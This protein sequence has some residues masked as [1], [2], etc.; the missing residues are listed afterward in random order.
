VDKEDKWWKELE[1]MEEYIEEKVKRIVESKEKRWKK[2]GKV[3]FGRNEYIFQT[4]PLFES[5]E[6]L[7]V[8]YVLRYQKIHTWL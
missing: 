7:V 3:I 6:L 1:D 2:E 8:S 4:Q 5:K